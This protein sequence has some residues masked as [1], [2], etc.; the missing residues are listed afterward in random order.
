MFKSTYFYRSVVSIIIALFFLGHTIEKIEIPLLDKVNN[1]LYDFRLSQTTVNTV[2]PRIVILDIDEKSLAQE[3]RWPW[4]RDKLSY[5][6]DIL[7]D[8]YQIKVLGFD[9]VFAEPDTSS[10]LNLLEKLGQNQLAQNEQ[11]QTVIESIKPQLNYDLAFA[12]SLQNRSVVMGYVFNNEKTTPSDSLLPKHA[13][14]LSL[15][16]SLNLF[17]SSSYSAN[18][19]V[20]QNA[21][22]SAGYFNNVTVDSDGSFRRVPLLMS[23]QDKVYES[24]SLAM[25]RKFYDDI[26]LGF[27]FGEGYVDGARLE[28]IRVATS[29]IP[30]TSQAVALVPYR[31]PYGSFEYISATDVLNGIIEPE[32]LNGKLVLLGTSAAG[33]LDMRTTPVGKVFPGVEVHANLLSGMLDNSFKSRPEFVLAIEFI[34]LSILSA[35]IILLYPRLSSISSAVMFALLLSIIVSTNFYLWQH[36]KLDTFLATPILLLFILFSVQLFFGYF[37]ETRKRNK[38]GRIFGQYIPAELV[39]D[40]S[41]TE[42]DYSLKGESKEMTVL[43]SDV[44]GFTTISENLSPEDLCV[45]INEVLTPITHVIHQNHGTIDKYIGDA[46]MAFWG[47]PLDNGNHALDAVKAALAFKPVIEQ[48]NKEFEPKGWPRIDLG[49]GLNTGPMNVGN[50]G[51]EFRMAY[52][53]M[54]DSVNLGSRLEGLTKQ[55]GCDIIV[56]EFTQQQTPEVAYLE[57]D[58]VRVKGKLEPVTIYEPIALYD[59]LTQEQQTMMRKHKEVLDLYYQREWTLALEILSNLITLFP[60]KKLF[61][62]YQSRVQEYQQNPPDKNWDGVFTHLS[63]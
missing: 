52:T 4:S 44:R 26:P 50:M 54:G 3:G 14:T 1:I 60:D 53:V 35:L 37:L 58:R 8:Y 20:I 24:L 57:L 33:L 48:I 5:L 18:L 39:S 7:F 6:V 38:L 51:S 30:V 11:Y 55:Y 41:K 40:M 16:P 56:S 19:A 23:F 63:K 28:A 13:S 12:N 32:T 62:I 47:A 10:G 49:I 46:V 21:A 27:Q 9:M 15:Q 59:T 61:T 29:N 45:L 2:D 36:L 25:L 17:E 31:G 42:H 22:K 34:A 43:F